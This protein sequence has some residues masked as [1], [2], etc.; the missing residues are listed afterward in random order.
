MRTLSRPAP[1]GVVPY[2]I[3]AEPEELLRVRERH[4]SFQYAPTCPFFGGPAWWGDVTPRRRTYRIEIRYLDQRGCP[5]PNRP[6]VFVPFLFPRLPNPHRLEDHSLCLDFPDDPASRRWI[7]KDGIVTLIDWSAIWLFTY[8]LWL[9]SALMDEDRE[10]LH[11]A[12]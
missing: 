12:V 8:E 3:G 1:R 9:T 2:R 5:F 10:W 6:H 4:P 11:P 7:Q